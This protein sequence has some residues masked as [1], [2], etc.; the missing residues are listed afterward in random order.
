MLYLTPEQVEQIHDVEVCGEGGLRGADHGRLKSAVLRCQAAPF[1][2]DQ[3]PT[4]HD[5]AAA[6][7]IGITR[8]HAFTG[9]NKRA[10]VLAT[11]VFYD[12][13]G[14]ELVAEADQAVGLTL[15]VA[16]HLAPDD[17]THRLVVEC[18]STWAQP[19]KYD[20]D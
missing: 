3:F 5:K 16:Q 15:M 2:Q 19:H 9:G 11:H 6:L 4:V 7:M 14:Y 20:G 12:I 1:G 8:A 13:N 18:L 17:H 10:A